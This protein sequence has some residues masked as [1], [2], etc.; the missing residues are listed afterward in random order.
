MIRYGSIVHCIDN[1][2]VKLVKVFQILG[3]RH[4]RKTNLFDFIWIIVKA[5]NLKAK[6][7]KESRQ[8]W[9]FRKGSMHRA[10]VVQTKQNFQRKNKMYISWNRNCVVL[11]DKYRVPLGT[12]ILQAIPTEITKKYPAI[13]AIC[14]WVI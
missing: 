4:K 5:R 1:T 8:R 14:Q 12:K 9:R 10:I 3:K 13:G 6:N 2:G 7:L 11:V